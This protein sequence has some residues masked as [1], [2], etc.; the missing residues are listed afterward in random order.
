MNAGL[1]KLKVVAPLVNAEDALRERGIAGGEEFLRSHRP[2]RR[3]RDVP[4]AYDDA[5]ED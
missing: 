4:Q 3:A 5:L 2:I 1:T